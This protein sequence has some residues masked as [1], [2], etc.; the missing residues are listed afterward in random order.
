L[1]KFKFAVGTLVRPKLIVTS[2]AVIG[3]KRSETNLEEDVFEIVAQRPYVT[4]LLTVGKAYKCKNTSDETHVEVFDEQDL[5]EV[6]VAVNADAANAA[7][8]AS[9]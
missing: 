5:A 8:A 6:A 9:N 4:R 2:S 7:D 1:V 3:V